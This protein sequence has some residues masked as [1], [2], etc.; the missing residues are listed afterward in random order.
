MRVVGTGQI[1]MGS[2][3]VLIGDAVNDLQK[4]LGLKKER[5][6]RLHR[7]LPNVRIIS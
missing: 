4:R 2:I 1:K 7:M 3:S 6:N 5:Q